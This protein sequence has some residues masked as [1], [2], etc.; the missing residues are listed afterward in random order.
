MSNRFIAVVVVLLVVFGGVFAIA[1]HKRS[2]PV[3][4]TAASP[5]SHIEG[6][7]AKNVTLV[8]YGDFEC[9]ACGA[10]YP[11][12]SQIF[13]KYKNDIHFQFRNFPLTQIHRHAF[14]ASRAGEAA[15]KQ[16]KFWEMYDMLYQNQKSW[17]AESDP[18]NSFVLYAKQLG[19]DTVKFKQDMQS[20]ESNDLINA[21]I[22][23]GTKLGANSTPTFVLEGKKIE[24]NPRSID[25]FN[26]LIDNAIAAK[27]KQ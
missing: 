1:K 24:N 25:E 2:G 18:T 10:Y 9:P 3:N 26:K 17:S 6:G 8:E 5:T 11:V 23:E 22:R 19:L 12:V 16:N 7:G 13:E 14:V 27:N 4:N 15:S 21:D 20:Q